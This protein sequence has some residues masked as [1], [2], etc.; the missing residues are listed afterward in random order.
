M[1]HRIMEL[2]SI[3]IWINSDVPVPIAGAA[4]DEVPSVQGRA[5]AAL[6]RPIRRHAALFVEKHCMGYGCCSY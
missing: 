4:G 5:L 6:R 2:S 3:L 1:I